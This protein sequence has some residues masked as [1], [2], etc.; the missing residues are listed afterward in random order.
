MLVNS[1]IE[2]STDFNLSYLKKN[3][4][5][6]V[7]QKLGNDVA[8]VSISHN[9]THIREMSKNHVFIK[10][11]EILILDINDSEIRLL[12]KAVLYKIANNENEIK[13]VISETSNSNDFKI[14]N[15][16]N[17]STQKQSDLNL[18]EN[19][20]YSLLNES[21][22]IIE[23]EIKEIDSAI[24]ETK[25]KNYFKSSENQATTKRR[26]R[27][28]IE[29]ENNQKSKLTILREKNGIELWEIAEKLGY[30]KQHYKTVESNNGYT[31]SKKN[32]IFINQFFRAIEDI[33]KERIEL[34]SQPFACMK[35]NKKGV[36]EE[37]LIYPPITEEIYQQAIQIM[38]TKRKNVIQTAILLGIDEEELNK[39]IAS[40]KENQYLSW[41]N[42]MYSI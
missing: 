42:V 40:D 31:S 25:L 35:S 11:R 39:K 12:P 33:K 3:F 1:Y 37:H 19:C 4:F 41:F 30:S 6:T 17:K 38:K 24:S 14:T 13:Q 23:Y 18:N 34:S 28:K 20:S 10:S 36:L 22:E 5:E 2:S 8:D 26:R 9:F 32:E 27:K 16:I 21:I 7:T 15:S 29:L